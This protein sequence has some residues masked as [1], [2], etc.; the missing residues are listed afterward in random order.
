MK[1]LEAYN[2]GKENGYTCANVNYRIG[3]SEE[4]LITLAFEAEENA[5]QYS[6]F[7]FYAKEMNDSK[8]STRTWGWYEKGVAQGI[9]EFCKKRKLK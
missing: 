3:M 8:D 9:I 2:L 1:K 6:P 7:E 4:R 5:R